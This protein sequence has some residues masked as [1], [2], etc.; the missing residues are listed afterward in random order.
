MKK[1]LIGIVI[2]LAVASFLTY[3]FIPSGISFSH[4]ISLRA[5]PQGLYRN[6]LNEKSWFKWWPENI[7][8]RNNDTLHNQFFYNGFTYTIDAK[9][10]SSILI[11]I[12]SST[13]KSKTALHLFPID[14]DSV[15]MIWEGRIPTSYNPIKR[16]RVYFKSKQLTNDINFTMKKID[17]FFSKTENIYGS[18]IQ[19]IPV[20]DSILISTYATSKD[21]PTTAFIYNL[22]DQLKEYIS[23][24]SAKE[25]GF[26]MLNVTTTDSITYLTRVAIP[27]NKKLKSS[28]NIS[29]RWMMG[30]GKILVSE[31]KGGPASIDTAFRQIE[32][33]INDYR[34]TAPA[35]PFLSLV[36]D[37]QKEPD[38]TKWVTKIYYPVM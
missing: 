35:I 37:R 15:Q 21:Y 1:W 5:N 22:I 34:R 7:N 9:K 17:S 25:T 27:V 31:I 33:Y 8:D 4:S 10:T 16:I 2:F 29:Y 3:L 24:Q 36:T 14:A 11:T 26:P 30:G 23:R 6:L 12:A 32:N 19:Q 20:L 13:V 28:G 38:T 18:D